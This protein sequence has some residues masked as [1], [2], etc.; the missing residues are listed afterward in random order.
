MRIALAGLGGAAT[1]GH[2]PALI[3]NRPDLQ[4]VAATDPDP[5]RPLPA[6]LSAIPRFDDAQEMLERIECDVLAIAT[7][8]Q[9]HAPLIA[10]AIERGL[11]VVCEKPLTVTRS[12]LDA[13]ARLCAERPDLAV[14]PVHQ[15]RYSPPWAGV[16]RWA[17]WAA[18]LGRLQLLS[19]DVQRV[20][21]DRH[22]SSPWRSD[23][24]T[25]GGM[26]AD[27]GVH[28]LALAWSIDPRL[29]LLA[30]VRRC[31]E[32]GGER[33]S[34]LFQ[35]RSGLLKLQVWNRAPVR[36]TSLDLRLTGASLAWRDHA[37]SLRVG[38]LDLRR[39]VAALS[40][41][42]HVDSLYE[43][44]YR[45]LAASLHSEVWRAR[46]TSEALGVTA[47]LVDLLERSPVEAAVAVGNG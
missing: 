38:G 23:L 32:T 12:D 30:A 47:A 37:A 36:R 20:G 21:T 4:L 8:P 39:E 5:G 43:P 29:D 15:Y 2:L 33:S 25:A 18:R 34:A 10:L 14:V 24:P 27:A 41:R 26:L 46:Q 9:Q 42:A 13:V 16:S 7:E 28:F 11:H 40:D 1:R 22:A 6:A 3:R 17:R 45:D 31:D 44:L 19:V 35:M